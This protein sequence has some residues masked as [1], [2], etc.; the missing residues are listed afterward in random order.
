MSCP[1]CKNQ[2]HETR[3]CPAYASL[4]VCVAHCRV[5]K[6]YIADIFTCNY[7]AMRR[8]P[9]ISKKQ[10]AE[11]L[12]VIGK[13]INMYSGKRNY[14]AWK[15]ETE[16]VEKLNEQILELIKERKELESI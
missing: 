10:A 8:K 9:K 15:G 11:R 3:Q 6:Y 1:I 7:V 2:A 13:L 12:F 5:C 14:L 4:P 16:E